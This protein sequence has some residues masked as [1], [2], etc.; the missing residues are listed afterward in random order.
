MPF[1]NEVSF[2][3]LKEEITLFHYPIAFFTHV[4]TCIFVLIF[5]FF[6]FS[7]YIR[8]QFKKVHKFFGYY[9]VLLNLVFAAPSGLVMGYYGNGGLYSKISFCIQAILWFI[10]TL[11]VLYFILKKK[12]NLHQNFMILSYPLTLST[13]SLRLFKWIIVTIWVFPPMDT[14]K[15]VYGWVGF[16]V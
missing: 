5:G 12:Y 6:Q 2:L 4:Y 1:N 11:F 8:N 3:E 9:Y 13:I 14:Y 7:K 10:F 16:L 15:I